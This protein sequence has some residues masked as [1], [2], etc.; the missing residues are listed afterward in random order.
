M[1]GIWFPGLGR[2]GFVACGGS[3]GTSS[4]VSVN[5]QGPVSRFIKRTPE[6]GSLEAAFRDS[7]KGLS[8]GI[9]SLPRGEVICRNLCIVDIAGEHSR[10]MSETS[11][12]AC[13]SAAQ[14][15]GRRQRSRTP[16]G[17]SA[18]RRGSWSRVEHPGASNPP[19]ERSL[20]MRVC[21]TV[22]GDSPSRS[23]GSGTPAGTVRLLQG[24]PGATTI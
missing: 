21:M 6:I 9:P 16:T 20:S 2:F 5:S 17:E 14:S 13:L 22:Q 3:A 1:D 15:V 7:W 24:A 23:G 10:W 12:K 19:D 8:S 11:A 4:C 18:S